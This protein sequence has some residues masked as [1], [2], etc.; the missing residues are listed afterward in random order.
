MPRLTRVQLNKAINDKIKAEFPAIYLT[1][2]D[3]SEGFT[4]PS[5]YVDIETVRTETYSY[6]QKREMNCRLRFFPTDRYEYKEEVYDVQDRL[7]DL[8]GINLQIEGR[9]I[10]LDK[11]ETD[12]MD[13]VL[14]YD[15]SFAY[16]DE[17]KEMAEQVEKMQELSFDV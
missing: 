11:A 5:F 9:T 14:Y 6:G 10:T 8:F 7:D 13:G 2:R 16:Y 12:I 15:F 1:S 3:V 4:R 17:V